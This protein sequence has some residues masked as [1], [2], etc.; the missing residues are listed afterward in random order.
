LKIAGLPAKSP[1]TIVV[2]ANDETSAAAQPQ[3]FFTLTVYAT[4]PVAISDPLDVLPYEV[5]LQGSWR[6]GVSYKS[7]LSTFVENP[8]YKL[9][10]P[11]GKVSAARVLALI[12]SKDEETAVNVTIAWSAG[13]RL[14]RY[15]HL[16]PKNPPTQY[17]TNPSYS[18]ANQDILCQ[19]GEYTPHHAK[20]S[21]AAIKPSTQYTL[22]ASRF[23]ESPLNDQFTLILRSSLPVTLSPL[24]EE[25]AGKSRKQITANWD[26][27]VK[28]FILATQRLTQFSVRLSAPAAKR[29]PFVRL[30]LRE[31]MSE[32]SLPEGS[33]LDGSL[34]GEGE[35][36]DGEEGMELV[37]SGEQYTDL[38]L[39]LACAIEGFDLVGGEEYVL[40]VERLGGERDDDGEFVLDFLADGEL[41]PVEI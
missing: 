23:E 30:S 11:E 35:E 1:S 32:A 16:P 33:L 29:A 6:K 19:S 13:K 22:I 31:G 26:D 24:R 20:T 7:P 36:E 3:R 38:G 10:V 39:G 15:H 17:T 8:Q 37:C 18:L 28:R 21:S 9:V 27:D 5:R 41:E 40:C 12:E 4:F 2:I 34:P 25:W 14:A